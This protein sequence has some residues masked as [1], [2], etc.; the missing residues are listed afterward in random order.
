MLRWWPVYFEAISDR[1]LA[2]ASRLTRP[3]HALTQNQ[4]NTIRPSG[5]P[6]Q[7][8]NPFNSQKPVILHINQESACV[9]L[10]DASDCKRFPLNL[11]LSPQGGEGIKRWPNVFDNLQ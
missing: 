6:P 4:T 7:R 10:K 5:H 3:Q 1:G 11:A 8:G 9:R 2:F